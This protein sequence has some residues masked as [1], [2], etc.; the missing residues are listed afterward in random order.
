M[1]RGQ[2]GGPAIKYAIAALA[3]AVFAATGVFVLHRNS[4]AISSVAA[5]QATGVFIGGLV[6]LA[7]G[8]AL[9]RFARLR[10]PRQKALARS[11]IALL[12]LG[13]IITALMI[14]YMGFVTLAHDKDATDPELADFTPALQRGRV[15]SAID[16]LNNGKLEQGFTRLTYVPGSTVQSDAYLEQERNIRAAMPPG[17]CRYDLKDIED[18]GVQGTKLVPG[19][20][21]PMQIYQMNADVDQQC[22]G[23][24]PVP[25]TLPILLV[26]HWGHWTPVAVGIR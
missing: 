10:Q 23:Q 24:S 1:N 16:A 9:H 21:E 17:G 15:Q 18:L 13:C 7:G 3:L 25:R 12:M 22:P 8:M 6:L 19:L 2:R 20:S 4:A 5:K 26:H 11:G 14:G